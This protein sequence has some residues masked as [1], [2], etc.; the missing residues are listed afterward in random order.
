MGQKTIP[1]LQTTTEIDGNALI[2]V[3]TGV[4]TFKIT[5]LNFAR[6]IFGIGT[7]PVITEKTDDFTIALGNENK[8]IPLN[9]ENGSFEAQLPDPTTVDGKTFILKD[10]GGKLSEF[11]VTVLRFAAEDI[12]E[13]AADYVCSG[14]FGCWRFYSNGTN[15]LLI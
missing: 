15:W 8:I 2:V 13:V 11:P 14:D 1:Q 5:A 12:E 6:S 7:L 3:D 9:S 4:Q 10:V